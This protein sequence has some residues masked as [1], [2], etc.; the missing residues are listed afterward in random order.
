MVRENHGE[1]VQS[2]G[3]LAVFSIESQGKYVFFSWRSGKNVQ[4]TE[5]DLKKLFPK[6]AWNRLHLQIIYYGRQYCTA[7]GCD[8]TVCEICTECYPRRR[9]PVVI[10]KA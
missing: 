7:R 6:A 4:Q 8:G 5:R 10:N 1:F 2:Q 9:T 3:K